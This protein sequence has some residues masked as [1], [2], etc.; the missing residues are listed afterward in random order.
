MAAFFV[1]A[2]AERSV[3]SNAWAKPR[4]DEHENAVYNITSNLVN[5]LLTK[6]ESGKHRSA[7][8]EA[9]RE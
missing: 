6:E 1:R 8:L 5:E 7:L 4:I 9:P 2:L 3:A